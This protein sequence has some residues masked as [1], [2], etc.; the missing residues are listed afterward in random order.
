MADSI[1]DFEEKTT[2]IDEEEPNL[3]YYKWE[4]ADV[5][6]I[7]TMLPPEKMG[8]LFYAVMETMETGLKVDVIDEIKAAYEW[9]FPKVIASRNKGI[10]ISK[11]RS[12]A[13]EKSAEVRRQKKENANKWTPPS[14]TAFKEMAK[15]IIKEY[16]VTSCDAYKITE[17][18]E[19]LSRRN[20][21]VYNL[22]IASNIVLK[23]VFLAFATE[24]AYIVQA[25]IKS[26][27]IDF[28][29]ETIADIA[30]ARMSANMW[31]YDTKK[32]TNIQDLISYFYRDDEE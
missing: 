18:Y 3:F 24:N 12:N 19:D 27:Q 5:K 15:H 14:K 25:L 20:W 10:E 8:Y 11:K 30:D 23:A 32:F 13:A 7:R 28:D 1:T 4:I 26:G 9:Y 17:I 29:T 16:S 2:V 6:L 22:E 31:E 21:V